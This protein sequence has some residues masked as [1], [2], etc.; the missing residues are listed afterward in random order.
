MRNKFNALV[1]LAGFFLLFMPKIQAE[2]ISVDAG[3]TPAQDRIIIRMQYRNM[4][5]KMGDNNLVMHMMPVVVAYGLTPDI[6]LMMRN[7]YRAVGKN[8][9]MMM[10]ENSWMDPFLMG[11]VKLYRHN[12]KKYVV[13]VAGFA[14]S[15]FPLW[16]SSASK[17][18]SP[19]LGI[20][21]SFRPKYWSFDLTNAYE[22]VNYNSEEKQSEAKQF[23]MNLA[24]SRNFVLRKLNNLVLAP[25]QEFSFVRSNPGMG[26][27]YS[28]GFISPGFQLVSPHVK[29][30][31]LYQ[32]P[33]NAPD[34]AMKN[35]G[36]LILG[37][38]L[39]F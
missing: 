27:A 35:G 6:T 12:T 32:I 37:V 3:L 14:G 13:G 1:L 8:E 26:D 18:Y 21:A 39:M 16:N 15:S 20:N 11:K 29:L 10:M 36:R 38:R 25:V 34:V 24:V 19:Q 23:Q 7:G 31:C 30:E 22:W 33:V 2:G 17:T 5:H 9:T 4:I 28:F